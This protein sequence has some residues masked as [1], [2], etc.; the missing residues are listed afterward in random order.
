MAMSK[1]DKVKDFYDNGLWNISRIRDAVEKNWITPEEFY[2]ITGIEYTE[3][4]K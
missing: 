1:Y 3:V 4:T 2:V